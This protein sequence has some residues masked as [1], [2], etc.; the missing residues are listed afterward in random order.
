MRTRHVLMLTAFTLAGAALTYGAPIPVCGAGAL[1][2]VYTNTDGSSNGYSCEIADKIYSNFSYTTAGA[3]PTAAQINV[4][5]DNNAS[6]SQTGL[7]IN[8]NVQGL[9]WDSAGFTLSYT[10]TVDPTACA[11]LYGAGT[12]C[13]ITGAQGQFQGAF[14]S[15]SA[16]M[17]MGLTPGGTISLNGLSP[18]NNTA[19]LTLGSQPV[20]STSV[21]ITGTSADTNDP[22]DS[23]GLDLYQTETIGPQSV[24]EPTTFTIVGAGLLG[25]S[26]L[27]R[28]TAR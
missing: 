9:T 8:S 6:I 19:N 26:L 17:T 16:A 21:L 11:S 13:T 24:P 3:D 23:F 20:T 5:I 10:V 25:L 12:T 22:I 27:R 2:G 1:A 7:Q 28:R 4:G 15:N 14:T 18:S